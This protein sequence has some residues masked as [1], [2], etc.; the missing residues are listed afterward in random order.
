M[1]RRRGTRVRSAFTLIELLVVVVVIGILA[2]IAISKF[3]NTKGKA[4]YAS[5]RSDLQNLATAEEAFFY[6]ARLYSANL[7]SVKAVRSPGV[8]LTVHEASA[9]GWSASG[10]H[11]SSWPRTCAIF[12]GNA[13]PVTPATDAGTVACN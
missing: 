8:I 10:Y 6:E 4:F 7:D 9:T 3:R 5:V 2:A 1:Y 13:A 12:F 11:P